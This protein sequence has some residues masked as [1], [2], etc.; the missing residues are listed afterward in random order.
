MKPQNLKTKI[1]LDSGDPKETVEAIKALGFLDGQTTN[2]TLIAKN[3]E[4]KERLAKGQKFS[5]L[6]IYEFYKKVV[7]DVS[8]L[9][10]Q[11]SV[12]VEVYADSETPSD[13]LLAQSREMFRWI[14][15]AHIKF[16]IIKGG[17]RAARYL[18]AEGARVNMTLCF[19]QEQAASVYAA[20]KGFGKGSVFISPFV[21]R[22]DDIGLNGMDLI[23]NIVKMYKRTDGD[24]EVLSA[25][26][27]N[28]DHFLYSIALG[29]DII[30]APLSI[31]KEWAAVGLPVPGVEYV[32]KTGALK[33]I[34]YKDFD[35]GKKWEE[36]DIKHELTDKG[37]ER[38]AKDWNELIRK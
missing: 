6:E 17:V 29:C 25:S 21:G 31:L 33:E 8:K 24:V 2:P 26:I 9:I 16:P 10:P 32:Y 38:F 12:S 3:P 34:E 15:N 27:R 13:K 7:T 1:F 23:K 18:L 28:M 22:L 37:I 14:P 5:E 19:S 11:G 4:A 35:L 30:T 20:M 36:Y